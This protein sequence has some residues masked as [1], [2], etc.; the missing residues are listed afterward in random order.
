MNPSLDELQFL[1]DAAMRRRPGT[2]LLK[3]VNLLNVFTLRIEATHI[4]LAGRWIAA[5]GEYLHSVQADEVVDLQGAYVSPGLID[6]HLHIESSLVVPAEY[7]RA[8]VPRGVT[9]IVADPHEVAN[10]AG[11]PAIEWMLDASEGLPLEVWFTVSSSVPSTAFETSGA[12][13][14]L[15]AIEK[16]LKHPRIIGVAELMSI[17][18]VT[19]ADPVELS[20]VRLAEQFGKLPDGHAPSLR[21]MP[22]QAYLAAGVASDHES[23]TFEEGL[24]KLAAGCFLMIREGSATR[25]LE[26]LMPLVDARYGDR[27]GFV[28]DDRLPHDLV[29]EGGVDF[30]VRKAVSL[31]ADP[32]FAVRAAS[33]NN[34]KYF[35]L[36]RRGA[37]APGYQADLVVLDDLNS[38]H[39]SAVYSQ[40]RL[41]A[42]HQKL[43]APIDDRPMA[44]CIRGTTKLPDLTE[45]DLALPF[46]RGRI[47][48]I[49][50]IPS[51]ILTKEM[52][53]EPTC[54][55]GQLAIDTARDLLKL[56]CV[57]RHGRHARCATSLV[58]GFGLKRGAIAGTIAHDHHNCMAVGTSDNDLL[59][60]VRRLGVLGGGMV[61]VLNGEVIAELPLPLAG[62][63]SDRSLSEV[64]QSMEELNFAVAKLDC[65]LPAPFMA[66]SFMGLAVIPELRLTDFGLVDVVKNCLV[67]MNVDRS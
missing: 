37:I 48:V 29:H 66:L 35:R 62:L 63:L 57:E 11:I 54:V 13:L 32:L 43:V 20:K 12:H 23:T 47:R 40:G 49:Q 42:E 41:V 53:V 15:A 16:L 21:G 9:G 60:A 18:G 22:L 56:L 7:A 46:S 55:D 59:T 31:G 27:I 2:L 6:A 58:H 5:V 10:V 30:L 14:D 28:T 52:I 64:C 50:A 51:Q 36:N 44:D 17:P 24:E 38:F 4:L 26:A 8:V 65:K 1:V 34:A 3:N 25:N 39:A 67:P 61:A 33:Y 19:S 45:A